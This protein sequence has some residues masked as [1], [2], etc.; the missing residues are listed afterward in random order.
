MAVS[1]LSEHRLAPPQCKT[2]ITPLSSLTCLWPTCAN[3][4]ILGAAMME[5]LLR[6][7]AGDTAVCS[8]GV[9]KCCLFV[10]SLPQTRCFRSPRA[11]SKLPNY[12][13]SARV[14]CVY[15]YLPCSPC[16]TGG[17]IPRSAGGGGGGAVS[18]LD[19]PTIRIDLWLVSLSRV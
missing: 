7:R 8:L 12:C 18:F 19:L 14:G 3:P 5:W 2:L 13:T 9:R 15:R 16:R 10:S 4:S 6:A 1:P 11:L 17:V